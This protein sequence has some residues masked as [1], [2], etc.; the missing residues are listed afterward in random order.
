MLLFAPKKI[1]LKV[2]DFQVFVIN[3]FGK[4]DTKVMYLKKNIMFI[5]IL[6]NF[7]LSLWNNILSK[8]KEI[9]TLDL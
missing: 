8:S 6:N 4:F 7:V 3:L 9:N 1:F 5:F 2:W